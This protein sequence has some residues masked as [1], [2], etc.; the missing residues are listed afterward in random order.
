MMLFRERLWP[1]WW[2]WPAALSWPLALGVAYGSAT[3]ATGG[4]VIGVLLSVAVTLALL[5][6]ATLIVVD[7]GRLRAGRA[8]LEAEYLGRPVPLGREAARRL[9]GVDADGR[10]FAVGRGW[11]A[12]AVQV[13]VDDSRD[14]TPYWYLSTRRPE[15]LAGAI[16]LARAAATDV[17]GFH[18]MPTTLEKPD[19]RQIQ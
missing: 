3:T 16:N 1:P 4:W 19:V 5:G 8:V 2:A 13:S 10:A 15:A 7:Q 14:P 12:T 17:Q 9:R 18:P 6:A 11:V